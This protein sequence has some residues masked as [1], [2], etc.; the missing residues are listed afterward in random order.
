MVLLINI[1][2]DE[3]LN[4]REM[5]I[6]LAMG[7]LS[8]YLEQKG[9]ECE[10]I[11]NG[12]EHI[13][14]NEII[15]RILTNNY[16]IV[17][18]STAT[19]NY[20]RIRV[21]VQKLRQ[22][23]YSGHITYGGHFASLAIREIL[24]DD[25]WV[26][27]II[28]GEG[29]I[30]LCELVKRISNGEGYKDILGLAYRNKNGEIIINT[31]RDRIYNLDEL[32]FPK[33]LGACKGYARIYSS[34][35]CY[36]NCSFCSIEAFYGNMG[37]KHWIGRSAENVVG[38]IDMLVGKHN[39]KHVVFVDD[40]FIGPGKKGKK[41]ASEIAYILINRR[42]NIG[43]DIECRA[44]D[45]DE[46]LFKELK[47]AGLR[48]VFL[49]VESGTEEDLALYKKDITAEQNI[50]A[51]KL[52]NELKIDAK[53]G[54]ILINPYTTLNRIK[55]NLIFLRKMAE[56][57]CIS[58]Q[59]IVSRMSIMPGY[60][61]YEKTLNEKRLFW[62]KQP[63]QYNFYMQEKDAELYYLIALKYFPINVYA[64]YDDLRKL[65]E[66]ITLK[67]G[68]QSDTY[69][70][71]KLLE[72]ELFKKELE[73]AEYIVNRIENDDLENIGDGVEHFR[74]AAEKVHKKA[75]MLRTLFQ[76]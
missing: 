6:S 35:G 36:G 25:N 56:T 41:R 12:I 18:F 49:G 29:E 8:A 65:K 37:I 7:Y 53:A 75:F 51:C 39:I 2:Q 43:F 26:D 54:Y 45:I 76:L 20:H 1:I 55:E 68:S 13:D 4:L 31:H 70:Q 52:L 57:N 40:N 60:G 15:Q 14:D 21:I 46:E 48:Q 59:C 16:K 5:G 24:T 9:Y 30:T 66:V 72:V 71:A 63:Y 62:G 34:R 44:N 47:A 61:I 10:I 50:K 32:P 58:S 28:I 73:F 19:S 17:G 74:V 22:R 67:S 38:E 23:G 64:T 42:Y 33:R 27:S 11:D 3:G 69:W